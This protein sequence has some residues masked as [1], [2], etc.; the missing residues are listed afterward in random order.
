MRAFILLVLACVWG[1]AAA[2]VYTWRDASGKVHYSDTP[3]P[4]VDA[5]RMRAGTHTG[6]TGSAAPV[7][8]TAEQDMEFRKRKAESD[9]SQAKAE[10]SARM[11]RKASATARTRGTSSTHWNP[12][13]A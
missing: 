9:K 13:S 1:V 5:K 6:T 7:R 3:P 10:R 8:S 4:G 11:P 2:Q 12:A